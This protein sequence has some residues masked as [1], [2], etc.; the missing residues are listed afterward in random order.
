MTGEVAHDLAVERRAGAAPRAWRG[1]G[2][3]SSASELVVDVLHRLLGQRRYRDGFLHL[4]VRALRRRR[5]GRRGARPG[6]RCRARRSFDPPGTSFSLCVKSTGSP[7]MGSPAAAGALVSSGMRMRRRSGWPS[8]TTP[9]MSKISRSWCSAVGQAGVTEGRAVVQRHARGHRDAVQRGHVEE[10]VV[11]AQARLVRVVVQA[12]DADQAAEAL[13]LQRG[14]GL[15]HRR[16]G[17]V[18]AGLAVL[19]PDGQDAVG[20][21]ILREHR[22]GGCVRH[23]GSP[24]PGTR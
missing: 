14:Q 7:P 12:V 6:G 18:Q 4:A 5:G 24:R 8:K 1:G 2:G 20:L 21:Q 15:G 16:R 9:N 22:Q 3:R 10:L 13:G 23:A 19:V 17:D 11:D